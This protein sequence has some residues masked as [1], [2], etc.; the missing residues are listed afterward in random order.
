MSNLEN[1]TFI[2]PL[3]IDS[4]DRM[5]NAIT[6]V[7]FLLQ[8]FDSKVIVKEHDSSKVFRDHGVPQIME[9]LEGREKNLIYVFEQSEN[10]VFH[11]TKYLNQMISM[12]QTEVVVNYDC[13]V[14]L[15]PETCHKAVDMIVNGGYDLIYPYGKGS[16][17]EQIFADDELVSEF[18]NEDF[19][20]DV[21]MKKSQNYLSDRGHVQFFKRSSYIAGGM[22]KENF[23]AYGPED[24]ERHDRFV[25]LGY[26]VGRIDDTVFHLEHKRT[27]N[28]WTT[29]PHY[30]DNMNLYEYLNG[31]TSEEL[32]EYYK[33]QDY[34]KKYS[35]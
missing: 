3:R 1:T 24:W 19:D 34:L 28:S 7:C 18:L 30:K 33:T 21:L 8:N 12:A 32:S 10:P 13:D 27:D 5:R 2:I 20:F 31:L 25:R 9:F 23:I 35:V 29:N 6:V 14:L 4:D 22:E 26:K 15:R 17:Q 11:R 16:Y